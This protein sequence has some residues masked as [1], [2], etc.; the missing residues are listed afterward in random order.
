MKHEGVSP[1]V[2]IEFLGDVRTK[3][4]MAT[5]W[6]FDRSSAQRSVDQGIGIGLAICDQVPLRQRSGG[7][8]Q[9][10]PYNE[11]LD[12]SGL[13]AAGHRGLPQVVDSPNLQ[14]AGNNRATGKLNLHLAV[15]GLPTRLVPNWGT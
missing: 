11:D 4:A 10:G 2:L 6:S 5:I 14:S 7:S 8:G 15:A 12:P 3:V 9:D 13:R 1:E